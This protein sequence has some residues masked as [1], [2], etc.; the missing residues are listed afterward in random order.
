[1]SKQ[2]SAKKTEN[3]DVLIKDIEMSAAPAVPKKTT[4]TRKAKY[5][6]L[7]SNFLMKE[8]KHELIGEPVI[9]EAG[10]QQ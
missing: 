9:T 3:V 6:T 5:I 1:M 2:A 8:T 7:Y 10:K 4:R